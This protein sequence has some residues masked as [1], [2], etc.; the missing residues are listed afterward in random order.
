MQN[1]IPLSAFA[2]AAL[3]TAACLTAPRAQVIRDQLAYLSPN[4]AESGKPIQVSVSGKTTLCNPQFS[5][6][7]VATEKGVLHLTVL[8]ENDPLAKCTAGE[9]DYAT[10]FQVPALKAGT[11]EVNLYL[12][13]AC[14]FSPTPCPIASQPLYA[15]TLTVQDSASL[16]Y[17]FRPKRTDANKAF[18]LFTFNKDYTCGNEFTNLSTSVSGHSLYVSFTNRPHPEAI[19]P[20]SLTDYGPTFKVPVMK[21]GVYQVFTVAMPYCG[22][23]GPC[24][25]ALVA[26]MLSGA[27]TVGDGAL[28]LQPVRQGARGEAASARGASGLSID[29]RHGVRG[30]WH[31]VSVSL[32]GRSQ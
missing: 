23:T 5:H 27:L 21:S 8:A 20:A 2:A 25:L 28:A 10:D 29:T 7:T 31:A 14:A 26:P 12:P 16:Y 6:H 15:G 9:H 17:A 3:I 18:D 32:T 4:Q 24:P 13:P 30:W 19:C 11:Y 22:T 1:R